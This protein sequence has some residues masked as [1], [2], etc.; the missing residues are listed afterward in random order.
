MNPSSKIT[1]INKEIE[2]TSNI[3]NENVYKILNRGEDIHQLREKASQLE[4][5]GKLFKKTNYLDNYL[6]ENEDTSIE[7]YEKHLITLMHDGQYQYVLDKASQ[8]GLIDMIKYIIEKSKYF[9]YNLY[10][11]N[12]LINASTMGHIDIVELLIEHDIDNEMYY[13]REPI[14]EYPTSYEL[15][16]FFTSS[17]ILKRPLSNLPLTHDD[18]IEAIKNAVLNNHLE[19][20]KI[21]D[22]YYFRTFAIKE[23]Y[24][25]NPPVP[26]DYQL[27]DN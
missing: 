10:I 22:K 3:L 16:G 18:L 14:L 19:I 11:N 17:P 5:I 13:G 1:Q 7:E 27:R 20:Q 8:L 23:L 2:N 12:A 15:F 24:N 21:L 4:D 6:T 26:I 25:K 9:Q